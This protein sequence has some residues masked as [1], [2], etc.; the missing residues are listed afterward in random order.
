ML[1]GFCCTGDAWELL[2]CNFVRPDRALLGTCL[3]AAWELL[4]SSLGA[5]S[6]LRGCCSGVAWMLL[7]FGCLS[8]GMLL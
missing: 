5:A 7:W 6:A 8:A 3:E 2:G 1:V 4:G